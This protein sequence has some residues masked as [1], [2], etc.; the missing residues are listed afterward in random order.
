MTLNQIHYFVT[1]ARFENYHSAANA[2]HISQ[3]SLSRSMAL[4]EEELK[5]PL[6]EKRGRGIVLTKAGHLFLERAYDIESTYQ[7]AIEAMEDIVSGGGRIDLGYVFP[8]AK[9][10][11]PTCLHSFL[12]NPKN[13][14]VSF[15]L[16]QESSAQMIQ[17]LQQG[18]LDVGF[19]FY[20]PSI[21]YPVDLHR[22][23]IFSLNLVVALPFNHPL[24]QEKVISLA[25]L[26]KYPMIGYDRTSFMYD[27]LQ[28]FYTQHQMNPHF[29]A[30]GGDEHILCSLVGQ[31]LGV[32]LMLENDE[33][34]DTDQIH[35][36]SLAEVT[37]SFEID[38]FW[39]EENKRLPGI[40]RFIHFVEND[41]I[42]NHLLDV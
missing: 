9:R 33:L 26:T 40:S 14:T 22:L 11:I 41:L 25:Q 16:H 29:V 17:H 2:L 30:Q 19:G 12:K 31:N 21:A 28:N 1:I 36:H 20:V 3:P 34:H 37:P 32:A 8:L 35:I 5:T 18:E 15:R 38:M 6:F 39:K 27:F 42:Y 23:K 24:T 4:L 7:G 13:E 10:F